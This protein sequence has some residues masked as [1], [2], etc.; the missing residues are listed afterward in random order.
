[1][2][3]RAD[4]WFDA[5]DLN[6]DGVISFVELSEHLAAQKFKPESIKCAFD[7]LDLNKDGEISRA[8]LQEC[9]LNYEDPA[10]RLALSLGASE[11]DDTFDAIDTNGD[12]MISRLELAQF[13]DRGTRSELPFLKFGEEDACVATLFEMYDTNGDGFISREELRDAYAADTEFRSFLGLP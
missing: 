8:E 10:L 5:V 9:F 12:G 6:G 2:N 11:A 4:E 13:L 7:L 1:M 3:I